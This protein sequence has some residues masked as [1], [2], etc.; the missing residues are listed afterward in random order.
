[1]SRTHFLVALLASALVALLPLALVA[2]M[3]SGSWSPTRF[4][5]ADLALV[6]PMLGAAKLGLGQIAGLL[7]SFLAY[8]AIAFG[9]LAWY[10]KSTGLELRQKDK[11]RSEV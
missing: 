8:W 3:T 11:D 1:M 9:L 4:R 10:I 7:L 2:W 5:L 6:L